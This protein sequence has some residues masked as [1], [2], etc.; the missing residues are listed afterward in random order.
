[1]GIRVTHTFKPLLHPQNIYINNCEV[2]FLAKAMSNK[3]PIHLTAAICLLFG[4]FIVLM[5]GV[6]CS[7]ILCYIEMLINR[8]KRP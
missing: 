5:S 7:N 3:Y 6:V 8:K 4:F 2:F 1:M